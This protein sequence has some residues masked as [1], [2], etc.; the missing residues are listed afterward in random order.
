MGVAA[1]L[2]LYALGL[3]VV[4]T[5]MFGVGSWVGPVLPRQQDHVEE[6]TGGGARP[7]DDGAGHEGEGGHEG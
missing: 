5:A 6:T 3:V 1:K 2:G 4:F 7:A